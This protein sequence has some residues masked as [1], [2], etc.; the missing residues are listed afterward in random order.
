MSLPRR[1]R[2][3]LG[4]SGG[5]LRSVPRPA[6]NLFEALN[7]QGI[8]CVVA[9]ACGCLLRAAPALVWEALPPLPDGDGIAGAFAGVSSG[10]LLVAGGANFPDRKPWEGGKKVWHDTVFALE[11]P[12]SSWKAVGHLPRPLAYGVSVSINGGVLCVGGSDTERHF[13]DTFQVHW[14]TGR[15]EV[16]PIASLPVPLANAA[17]A[18]VSNTVYVVG[19]SEAPGEQAASRRCFTLSF[20]WKALQWREIE[21]LPGKPR[22]LPVAATLGGAFY[23][24]GG[25][26]LEPKDGK[27]KRIYLRDTWRFR[28]GI[29]WQRLADLPKPAVASPSPAPAIGQHLYLLGGDDGSLAGFQPMENHPGFPKSMMRYDA[30]RDAWRVWDELPVSRVTVPVVEWLGRFVIPSGE[31]RPGVRSP[32]VWTLGPGR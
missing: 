32:E 24:M 1:F 26:A 19:G 30:M 10:A 15:I 29:G 13:A 25:A 7:L 12:G 3:E 2:T 21:P 18:V 8:C 28:P 22:I 11:A 4:F 6:R 16:T 5:L 20:D 14:H 23:V 27:V 17:G 9:L 31:V